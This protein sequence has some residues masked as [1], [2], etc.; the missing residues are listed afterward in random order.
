[1]FKNRDEAGIQLGQALKGR[2]YERPIVLGIPRGGVVPAAQVARALGGD[3]GVVVAR[4]LGAPYQRE[5]AIGAVTADGVA[6]VNE[7]LV[8]DIGVDPEYLRAEAARQ[9]A[10]A[11]RREA[12]FDGHRRPPIKGRTVIIVDDGL[13]TGATAIAATRSMKAAGAG[14]VIVAVPVGPSH[15]VRALEDEADEVFALE[16]RDDF[17]AIGQFYRDFTQVE[18]AEA[19]RILADFEREH[20]RAGTVAGGPVPNAPSAEVGAGANRR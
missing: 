5:L 14:R 17:M 3:L 12:A 18:D 10:E 19:R 6:W 9:A 16:V 15:T 7:E 1:M 4:K 13:A 20:A 8:R 2:G 11:A